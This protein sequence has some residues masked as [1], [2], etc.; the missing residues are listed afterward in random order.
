MQ[1]LLIVLRWFIGLLFIF[2]GL[3]KANDPL[4]LS[5]KMQEF[6]EAWHLQL[7]NDYTLALSLAMNVFE[8]LAGVAV[9]VGYRMR[10]FSWL[11]LLLILFFTFLTGYASL[12]G[13]FK[14]C[15]C[16][17][18]CLPLTPIQSFGKD[19]L[20]LIL[21]VIIFIH[22]K[23]IKPLF[24]RTTISVVIL[25]CSVLAV[26]FAQGYVLK[27]LPF[28]D[29]LPYKAGNNL[30][31]QMKVPTGAVPDSFSV[32]FKY[33]KQ[34]KIVEFDA[35]H[36]P[37]DFNDSTYQYV[38]RYDKLIRKGNAT[39]AI[40]DFALKT[41]S[42]TDTTQDILNQPNLYVLAFIKDFD[43]WDKQK[44]VFEKIAA[45][46]KQKNKPL[47]VVTASPENAQKILPQGTI[48]LACDA[49]VIKTAARVNATYFLMRGATVLKKHSYTDA[50]KIWNLYR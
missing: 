18:D 12:S 3:V 47:F 33:L 43:N 32:T 41:M 5:Y 22:R 13:K 7:L 44:S 24:R 11:L 6:F 10:L 8:V 4:G 9:I 37:Q 40:E 27:R 17:G 23:K 2:S 38:E 48:I 42:G 15:G 46:A 14:S 50:E 1:K 29:C 36:F 28:A 34:G 35:Q 25:L 16:F 19:L 30:L 45:S 49:T 31:E 21:I 20:L 39:P 26:L